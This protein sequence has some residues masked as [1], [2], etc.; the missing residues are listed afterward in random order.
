MW[1]GSI[2][3]AGER[4][5]KKKKPPDWLQED[6]SKVERRIL[7]DPIIQQVAN[8]ASQKEVSLYLV[9]GAIRDILLKRTVRDYDFVLKKT[10]RSF[11]DQLGDL[12]E[13]SLFPMGKGRQEQ[14]YRLGQG[15]TTHK[16]A[17]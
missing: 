10:S 2:L 11:L 6:F 17:V 15:E 8:A 9:G 1:W 3:V 7:T 14:V 12:L 16:L 13:A 5:Q 4:T